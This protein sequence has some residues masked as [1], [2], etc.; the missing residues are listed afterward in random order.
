MLINTVKNP[1]A[2]TNTASLAPGSNGAVGIST[3]AVTGLG[4][5]SYY[6]QSNTAAQSS[7]GLVASDYGVAKPGERWHFRCRARLGGMIGA[8]RLRTDLIFRNASG[9]ALAYIPAAVDFIPDGVFHRWLGTANASASER[10]EAG[11]RRV[12]DITDPLFTNSNAW[13][14]NPSATYDFASVPGAVVIGVTTAFPANGALVTYPAQG[15]AVGEF[16]SPKASSYRITNKGPTA[17]SFYGNTRA[18]GSTAST[19]GPSSADLLLEPGASGVLRI[20]AVVPTGDNLLGYRPLIRTRSVIPAGHVIQVSEAI[21]ET[22]ATSNDI[23]GSFFSG[24]SANTGTGKSTDVLDL[25]VSAVAPAGTA[26]VS[27]S[28]YRMT[29]YQPGANDIIYVDNL[30]LVEQDGPTPPYG[31][32]SI[33]GWNWEGAPNASRSLKL[34]TAPV[35]TLVEGD[36]LAGPRARLAF[37]ELLPGTVRLTVYRN[38]DR[39]LWKVRDAVDVSVNGSIERPDY[40]IPFN[41]DSAYYAMQYDAQG[42]ELGYTES[43]TVNFQQDE[44]VVWFH[45]PLDP[46]QRVRTAYRSTAAQSIVRP[47][48]GEVV[49]IEGRSVGV[50]VARGRQGLTGVNLDIVTETHADADAFSDM[51]GTY[52]ER[53]IPIAVV[54]SAGPTRIPKTLFAAIMSPEEQ[55]AT[56]HLGG[57]L[58]NWELKADEVTPPAES[59]IIPLLTYNDFNAYYANSNYAKFNSDYATYAQANVDYSK[60][61]TY[62]AQ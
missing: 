40:E 31:D 45:Y 17:V 10:L 44:D 52:S 26:S 32:G 51:F 7:F 24:A 39:R 57:A 42:G 43:T 34:E 38:S 50:L 14:R 8:R 23:T 13:Y 22:V 37:N 30:M 41:V 59:L 49:Q 18:Y 35:V 29:D 20:P 19:D 58:V 5:R 62:S 27:F 61:G 6:L 54:R 46:K 48:R 33:A 28:L 53:R 11:A 2:E 4:A 9:A 1:S 21:G 55:D 60:A 15:Q 25:V 36:N 47:S 56:V 3:D 12:N 16:G